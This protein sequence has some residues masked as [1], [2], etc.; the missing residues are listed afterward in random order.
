[1][2]EVNKKRKVE[3]AQIAIAIVTRTMGHVTIK[4]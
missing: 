4:M 3:L 1:M 2:T